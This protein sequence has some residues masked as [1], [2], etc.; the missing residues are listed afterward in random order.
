MFFLANE[1]GEKRYESIP[2]NPTISSLLQPSNER[3]NSDNPY[4]FR[5][6]YTTDARRT[7][8]ENNYESTKRT[9]DYRFTETD[10]SDNTRRVPTADVFV[11]P[12]RR[13][14]HGNARTAVMEVNISV[15]LGGA[16]VGY[17]DR[18]PHTTTNTKEPVIRSTAFLEDARYV[19]LSFRVPEHGAQLRTDG[20]IRESSPR[21]TSDL[22][23]K[24]SEK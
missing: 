4:S 2:E 5:E 22:P 9:G 12:Y 11:D 1:S 23:K 3:R 15:S 7:G 19:D 24:I 14:Q 6:Q 17:A 20:I 21:Y 18:T 10:R 8:G 13:P 16:S